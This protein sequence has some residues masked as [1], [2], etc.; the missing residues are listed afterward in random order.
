MNT[1]E[2]QQYNIIYYQNNLILTSSQ[3]MVNEFRK[4][5]SPI[6]Y[7]FT[8]IYNISIL[9]ILMKKKIYYILKIFIQ[10]YFNAY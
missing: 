9:S 7:Y 2:F 3:L 6:V 1:K 5:K 4:H 10:T 8:R